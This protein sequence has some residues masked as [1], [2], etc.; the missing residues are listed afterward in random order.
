[1]GFKRNI[2]LIDTLPLIKKD[3]HFTEEKHK[4]RNI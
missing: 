4:E 3:L 1:M 2:S